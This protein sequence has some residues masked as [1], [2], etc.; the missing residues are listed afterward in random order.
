MI[1]PTKDSQRPRPSTRGP[2]PVAPVLGDR[3]HEIRSQLWLLSN[4]A[5]AALVDHGTLL[6]VK[7]DW[8]KLSV[9]PAM[10]VL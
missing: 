2:G 3:G 1:R 4:C 5:L 6:K 9:D 7:N 10:P 8:T